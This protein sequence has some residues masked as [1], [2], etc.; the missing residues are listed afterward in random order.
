MGRRAT[1][2]ARAR[3]GLA[4]GVLADV[5]TARRL[6]GRDGRRA[7]GPAAI[8]RPEATATKPEAMGVGEPINAAYVPGALDDD[9]RGG[10]L[11]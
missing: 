5:D 2:V 1:R 10:R 3:R 4:G 7:V 9:G 11:P 8:R 6:T